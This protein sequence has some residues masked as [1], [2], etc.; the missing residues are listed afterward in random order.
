MVV[1]TVSS[2]NQRQ[3]VVFDELFGVFIP[4]VTTEKLSDALSSTYVCLPLPEN[5]IFFIDAPDGSGKT[6]LTKTLL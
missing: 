3:K 6:F 4:E 5:R 2:L 1:S